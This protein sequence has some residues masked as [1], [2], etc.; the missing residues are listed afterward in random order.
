MISAR[1]GFTIA[2]FFAVLGLISAQADAAIHRID[3]RVTDGQGEFYNTETGE[4]FAP[5]GVNYIG[6][7][8][9]G[10]GLRNRILDTSL[11]DRDAVRAD[12]RRLSQAGY[13]TVRIFFDSCNAGPTCIGSTT[14]PGL[15][16]AYIANIADLIQIAADEH[17]Y[18]VLT[19]NDLPDDGGYWEMSNRGES[20]QFAGYRNAHYLT[21]PGHASAARYWRD[22]MSALMAHNPPTKAVLGWSLLNEQWFFK[23]Q[24]PLS[25]TEGNVTTANGV[26]YDLADPA[27]KRAMLVDN[28]VRYID[29]TSAVIREYDPGTLVTMGFFAPQFPNETEIGG[30]WYVDTEP[31]L[32]RAA[33]DFF[34]FHAYPGE[35]IPLPQIA[36]NFGML[37][38]PTVPVIMGEVGAFRGRFEQADVGAIALQEW[39]AASCQLGFDGWLLWD[40]FGA[41][42]SVGDAA[43]G[44]IAEDG[45][46]FDALAPVNQPDPCQTTDLRTANIAFRQSV[47][48]SRSLPAEPPANVTDGSDA[49]WGAGADAPQWVEIDLGG[50]FSVTEV[51]LQV[52]QYP[53]GDT[54]HQVW[55]INDQGLRI[56]LQEFDQSTQEG[57]VL[58]AALDAPVPDARVLRV[59]TLVSPSWVAWREIEAYEGGTG[60]ACIVQAGGTVNLRTE[61]STASA[62]VGTLAA[63][64][65]AVVISQRDGDDGFI[66]YRLQQGAWVREDVLTL[67]GDCADLPAVD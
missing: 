1:F 23:R 21:A 18:L 67:F 33:L 47:T 6:W 20:P 39:I 3:V 5:R 36:E 54:R 43:W 38:H 31:L 11:Y 63:S 29:V 22:F 46:I 52:A 41:P 8:P 48:A 28:I 10:A 17:L 14:G 15:N 45:A 7:Q 50:T 60:S 9:T 56:L 34:D 62:A 57:D 35:D 44:M 24:P 58:I 2:V 65:G 40:Y 66:W 64:R 59:E 30:D 37:D 13:N 51:R 42:L 16:P 55:V 19:S 32:A 61:A 12:F 49:Q 53:A 27:Q 26:T 25:L 4:T